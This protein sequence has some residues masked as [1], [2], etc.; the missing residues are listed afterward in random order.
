MAY[1]ILVRPNYGHHE[2]AGNC[3]PMAQK[4]VGAGGGPHSATAAANATR[5]QHHDR[6]LPGDAPAVV[7]LSH[8]GTYTDYRDGVLKYENWGHV[9]IWEPTAFANA[10]GFF[11]S[12]RNGYGV[13]EWFRTIEDVE[14]AF[15]SSYRFWSEDINGVR[16]IAPTGKHAASVA[17]EEN[18]KHFG[19]GL[20]RKS[21]QVIPAGVRTRLAWSDAPSGGE[22]IA[23]GAG[24]IVGLVAT[25][26]LKL[27][28]GT[29]ATPD[30]R[31]EIGAYRETGRSDPNRLHIM[32]PR[33]VTF[34]KLGLAQLQ[35][36]I[37]KP[38]TAADR[39]RITVHTSKETGPVT[40][41]A[42]D[43]DGY[44]NP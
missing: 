11:S 12:R 17:G 31:A 6:A 30:M 26:R 4:V 33:A 10:G 27:K 44:V 41:E 18:M 32:G 16:V 29:K 13:G 43:W 5:Y 15:S 7:W 21:P 28:P 42:F 24:N 1:K 40:V 14:R 23:G 8:W 37:S 38:L 22:S 39:I 25:V 3:L 20:K 34:D 9:V 2:Y 19:G 35:I 36:M